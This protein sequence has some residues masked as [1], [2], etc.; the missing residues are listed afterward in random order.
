MP[1]ALRSELHG[2]L[3]SWLDGRPAGTD[4]MIGYHLEQAYRYRAE[5]RPP[6]EAALDLGRRGAERLARAGRGAYARDDMSAAASLTSR[7]AELLPRND[8]GWLELLL[9]LPEALLWQGRL[10]EAAAVSEEAIRSA[11]AIGDRRI[12]WRAV[13]WRSTVQR[14]L[15]PKEWA[16]QGRH[17]AEEAIQALDEIGDDAGLAHAWW[18]ISEVDGVEAHYGAGEEALERA[19]IHARRVGDEYQERRILAHLAETKLRGSTPVDIAI[20]AIEQQL[21]LASANP[22]LEAECCEILALLRA[23][24]GQFAEARALVTADM[25]DDNSRFRAASGA[26]VRA[27]VE[28]LAGDSMA[29]EPEYQTAYMLYAEAGNT[30]GT[31]GAAAELAHCLWAQGRDDEALRFTEVSEEAASD[32]VE[33]QVRWRG[34]RAKVLA[35]RGELTEAQRFAREAVVLVEVTDALNLRGDALMDLAE[36]LR[37]AERPADAAPV[38]E[39]ALRHYQRKGNL[40][41]ASRARVALEELEAMLSASD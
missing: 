22:Y 17:E 19:L 1:R 21:A 3:A 26:W 11:R 24:L 2:R 6:D 25:R 28:M 33:T 23:M 20:P 7:A 18:L 14:M 10:V 31:S 35:R 41:S 34:V 5:L 32:V 27:L 8:P 12:E 37:L 39:E 38:V 40:V 13:L 36:V 16:R 30:T 15:R 29:A 9:Q 4:E